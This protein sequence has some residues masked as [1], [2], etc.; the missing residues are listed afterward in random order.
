MLDG[1]V[2]A[3]Q[4]EYKPFG[5]PPLQRELHHCHGAGQY[6]GAL[7]HSCNISCQQG[8][9]RRARRGQ[10]QRGSESKAEGSEQT[11]M[12]KAAPKLKAKA[13]P[14]PLTGWC[15]LQAAI[16]QG[17]YSH[18]CLQVLCKLG[19]KCLQMSWGPLRFVDSMN[20]FPTSLTSMIDNLRAARTSSCR[21]SS[22]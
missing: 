3:S 5:K 7:C 16:K 22:R 12:P 1:R 21:S 20:V 2:E 6:L 14:K 4:V 13:A 9:A 8:A 10:R 11:A 19:E 18:L 15:A 17:D